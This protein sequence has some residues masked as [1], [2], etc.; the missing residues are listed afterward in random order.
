MKPPFMLSRDT[1]SHDTVEVLQVL[2]EEAKK[3]NLIGI[4]F[5]T[6]YTKPSR[7][8][9]TEAAGEADRNP[10]FAIG[11]VVVLLYRLVMKAVGK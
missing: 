8:Y 3:G 11:I 6:M 2:L 10:T 7:R 9:T 1:I 5:A 4:V